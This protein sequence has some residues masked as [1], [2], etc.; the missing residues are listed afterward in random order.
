MALPWKGGPLFLLHCLLYKLAP[1]AASVEGCSEAWW[2]S[3]WA[4][5]VLPP[6]HFVCLCSS[7]S[8]GGG[9]LGL[10]PNGIEASPTSTRYRTRPCPSLPKACPLLFCDQIWGLLR[11]RWT[12][13]G[14]GQ[15]RAKQEWACAW[16]VALQTGLRLHGDRRMVT[17][18]FAC[19]VPWPVP[20]AQ[21][22]GESGPCPC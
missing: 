9:R 17:R 13:S 22:L 2:G 21:E 8:S 10:Q 11:L 1:L 14:C 3:L 16:A 6:F 15:Y 20:C 12:L 19:F 18:R 7:G 4:V 5:Q